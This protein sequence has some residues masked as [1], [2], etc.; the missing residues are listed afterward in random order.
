MPEYGPL[1][2]DE[3]KHR[4]SVLHEKIKCLNDFGVVHIIRELPWLLDIVAA[5]EAENARLTLLAAL[6][7][8][9]EA[10]PVGFG[11]SHAAADL[12]LIWDNRDSDDLDETCG[13]TALVALQKLAARRA[14][15][16][17]GNTD[18]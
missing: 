1:D 3:R 15:N 6:G 5:L 2:V 18:A 13:E 4:I 11:L 10:M 14:A 7:E 16:R 17:G 12:W 8:A 9:V